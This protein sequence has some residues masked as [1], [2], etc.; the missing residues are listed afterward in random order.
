MISNS[1]KIDI[2]HRIPV[3]LG[4]EHI[5]KG[6][7]PIL[8]CNRLADSKTRVNRS[9]RVTNGVAAIERSVPVVKVKQDDYDLRRAGLSD[10]AQPVNDKRISDSNPFGQSM[11]PH[12]KRDGE[13]I[14]VSFHFDDI[15][16]KFPADSAE[17]SVIE[18][19]QRLADSSL[20]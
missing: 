11:G 6:D 18:F 13:F 1:E 5:Q 16:K 14:E 19:W 4:M 12:A 3:Q 17:S 9:G 2:M 20:R 15:V 8:G 7:N 10:I